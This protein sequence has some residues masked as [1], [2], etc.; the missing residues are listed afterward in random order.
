MGAGICGTYVIEWA[1]TELGGV[2]GGALDDLRAGALWRWSGRA[3]RLD[4]PQDLLRLGGA[5]G[6]DRLHERARARIGGPRRSPFDALD[7]VLGHGFSVTDGRAAFWLAVV[8]EG[9]TPLLV[10]HDG[11]PPAQTDLWV[12]KT[13]LASAP[14]RMPLPAPAAHGVLDSARI[15]T[16]DGPRRAGSLAVG[17]RVM[18]SDAG[19][20]PIRWLGTQHLSA[21]RVMLTPALRPLHAGRGGG[22]GDLHVAPSQ[23]LLVSGR[24]ARDLFNAEGVLAP[25]HALE[26]QWLPSTRRAPLCYVQIVLERHHILHAQGQ[27]VASTHLDDLDPAAL[28]LR[29]RAVL[30]RLFGHAEG[31]GPYARRVLSRPETAL[32]QAA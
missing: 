3:T 25:A 24:G 21:A 22:G 14:R 30:R 17:D 28:S 11:V 32:L 23:L 6:L 10:C 20:Q 31:Y 19:P 2:S 8:A 15:D 27:G 7:P 18:T 4:G 29:D 16:P 1:Q 13:D 26:T 5:L 9:S 12:V